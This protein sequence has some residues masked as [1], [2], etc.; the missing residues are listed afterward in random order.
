[1]AYDRFGTEHVLAAVDVRPELDPFLADVPQVFEAEALKASAIRQ[2]RTVPRHE[3][4]EA[5]R[6]P[7]RLHAGPEIQVVGVPEQNR[8]SHPAK[9]VR[10]NRLDR[11]QCRYG[12]EGRGRHVTVRRVERPNTGT[13]LGLVKCETCHDFRLWASLFLT[14]C[15]SRFTSLYSRPGLGNRVLC[16][17]HVLPARPPQFDNNKNNASKCHRMSQFSRIHAA[18]VTMS[19]PTP[20]ALMSSD[21]RPAR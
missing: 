9:V 18:I 21:M 19:D 6:I 7:N 3:R 20:I 10:I 16:S 2:R 13:A 15:P 4:R 11:A 1:M 14:A 5:A 12:H 8:R 17:V